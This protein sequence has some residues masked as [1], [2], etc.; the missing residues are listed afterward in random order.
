[1][2]MEEFYFTNN[3]WF[4][5]EVRLQIVEYRTLINSHVH[6]H[7]NPLNGTVIGGPG[8]IRD[9]VSMRTLSRCVYKF[10]FVAGLSLLK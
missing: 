2:K 8:T 5:Q 10:V 7:G 3:Q 4:F 9:S 1:M 6:P